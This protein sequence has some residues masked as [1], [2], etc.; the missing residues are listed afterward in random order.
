[1]LLWA[2]NFI[3]KKVGTE[4]QDECWTT[5]ETFTINFMNQIKIKHLSYFLINKDI[6]NVDRPNRYTKLERRLRRHFN[7]F[8]DVLSFSK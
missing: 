8:D 1:M 7:L 6:Q 4:V 3:N 5:F 2:I